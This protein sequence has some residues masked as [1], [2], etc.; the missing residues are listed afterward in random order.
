MA[1]L[2]ISAL[3][4]AAS[5]VDGALVPIVQAGGNASATLG[6]LAGHVNA[7]QRIFGFIPAGPIPTL[8][9]D[10]A[11]WT[12]TLTQAGEWSYY[13]N[14][15]RYTV[16]GNKSLTLPYT[17]AVVA[18][19]AAEVPPTAGMWWIR[20]AGND[21][22]L[23]ASQTPWTLSATDEDVTV[24]SIEINATKT[25]KSLVYTEMHLCDINRGMHRYEHISTGPKLVSGGVVSGQTLSGNTTATNTC[26]ISAAYYMDETLV[27]TVPELVDDNGSTAKY[28]IRSRSGGAFTWALSLVPYLYAPGSYIYWDNAG[29][30]TAAA[31]NRYVNTYLLATQAGWQFFTG[32]ASHTAL[33]T[34]QAET[35]QTLNLTG[36]QLSD[37]I[38]VAQMTWRTGSYGG[39]GLC[40]LE[41]FARV[42]IAS[43]T[44]GTF[45]GQLASDV[46]FT[47]TA[48]INETDV[49]SAI[50]LVDTKITS[51]AIPFITALAMGA[52]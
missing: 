17:P 38:V 41:A 29:T 16:T 43:I 28:L 31:S 6:Q 3:T 37:Y 8:T 5:V 20:I 45:T 40:R 21:G 51:S 50:E 24:C 1:N 44:V 42:N 23:S 27:V 25:P 52:L 12:V 14:S 18:P 33:A 30:L 39:L 36:F 46:R 35:F 22:E 13:R 48:T 49:Q 19:P 47:P 4:P 15:I 2:K 32:Q 10:E 26:G 34:A 7:D 11:T 9:W